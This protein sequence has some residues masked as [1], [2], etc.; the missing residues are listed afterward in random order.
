[1][2]H[3]ESWA[4]RR[5]NR[6]SEWMNR[7]LFRKL[8]RMLL[9]GAPEA[10]RILEIGVGRRLFYDAL[11]QTNSQIQYTG[12]EPNPQMFQDACAKG[13]DCVQ[14]FVPPFPEG[15]APGSFDFVLM[16]HVLEHFRDYREVMAVF[17]GVRGLLAAGGRFVLFYPDLRDYGVDF[18]E[19]DYTHT[20][21][22][23]RDNVRDLLA[24]CGFA[25]EVE[26]SYRACFHSC[27]PV[28]WAVAKCV[29]LAAGFLYNATGKKKWLKARTTF[30]RNLL[31][32]CK[33]KEA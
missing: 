27:R 5:R 16:S 33:K 11:K 29:G 1:M 32:V 20:F 17:E 19:A 2:S 24:D 25:V 30:K 6:V 18:F 26:D 21:P 14:C 10:P 7:R 22:A 13:I 8:S 28:F 4:L 15:L 9:R 12:I 31:F 3:Y 23:A